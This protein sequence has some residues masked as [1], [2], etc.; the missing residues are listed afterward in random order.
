MIWYL[1]TILLAIG[2]IICSKDP[3]KAEPFSCLTCVT[4]VIVLIVSL[5]ISG[6]VI[7]HETRLDE[8]IGNLKV[9]EERFEEI[10]QT[11]LIY[12]GKYPLEENLFKNFNPAILFKVPEIKSDEFLI[13][14][15][16]L[17][18]K[19]Q[20]EIFNWKMRVNARKQALDFHGRRWFSPTFEAPNYEGMRN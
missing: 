4:L 1:P 9:A 15:I 7:S 12:T 19:H 20:N 18:V 2:W 3:K 5:I 8:A 10:Q 14:Q 11:I 6:L 17:A 16:N 13:N